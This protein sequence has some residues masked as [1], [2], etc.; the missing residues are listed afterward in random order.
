MKAL[1]P[2]L[3]RRN[4]EVHKNPRLDFSCNWRH[5]SRSCWTAA[6]NSPPFV[7]GFLVKRYTLMHTHTH[8]Q[9]GD[10][11]KTQTPPNTLTKFPIKPSASLEYSIVV[12][13]VK[14]SW[15]IFK[16]QSRVPT[17]FLGETVNTYMRVEMER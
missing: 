13:V 14:V 10:T 5:R 8:T 3:T 6:D 12:V 15:S 1:S 7:K 11:Q 16:S 17:F 4:R 9:R 2:K